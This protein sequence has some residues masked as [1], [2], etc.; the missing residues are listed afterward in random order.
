M[1]GERWPIKCATF[2]MTKFKTIYHLHKIYVYFF[3]LMTPLHQKLGTDRDDKICLQILYKIL[4]RNINSYKYGHSVIIW[5][6][7][8]QI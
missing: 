5:G 3:G 4:F 1:F 7:V 2:I 6:Y 8:Q